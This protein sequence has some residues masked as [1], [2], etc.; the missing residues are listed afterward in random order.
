MVQRVPSFLPAFSIEV[1]L[2]PS[3]NIVI[4]SKGYFTKDSRGV[5]SGL[6]LQQSVFFQFAM[7]N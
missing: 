1:A 6:S 2:I 4:P 5:K 7:Q 3:L